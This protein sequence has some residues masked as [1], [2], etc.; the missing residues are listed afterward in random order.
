MSVSVFVASSLWCNS[1]ISGEFATSAHFG[2]WNYKFVLP[3]YKRWFTQQSDIT[4]SLVNFMLNWNM[5][6]I[7]RVHPAS[8]RTL[9]YHRELAIF[10]CFT[11]ETQRD[12]NN[13]FLRKQFFFSKLERFDDTTKTLNFINHNNSNEK[14][15]QKKFLDIG[16]C[17]IYWNWKNHN[18]EIGNNLLIIL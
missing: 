2:L 12:F 17:L 11:C 10:T 6:K 7:R 16:R 5:W 18:I 1:F 9:F 13:N 3:I 14:C 8:G 4:S 15:S